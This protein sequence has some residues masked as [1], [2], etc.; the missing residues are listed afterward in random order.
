[1]AR[2]PSESMDATLPT[3]TVRHNLREDI[4]SGRL[5][6]GLRLKFA[7]LQARYEASVGTL[8]EALSELVADGL[9]VAETNRGFAVA[10]VSVAELLDITELR[11]DLE[12]KALTASIQHGDDEWEARVLAAFHLLQ[13]A[14]GELRRDRAESSIWVERH[15]RFHD[16]LVSACPSPWVLRFRQTLFD[17]ARRYRALSMKHSASPGRMEE[18]RKLMEAALGRD[19]EAAGAASEAHI[20]GTARN[21]LDSV[22]GYRGHA[23]AADDRNAARARPRRT[24]QS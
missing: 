21:I 2:T 17:Q 16:A 14:E 1:M 20:R 19:V 22:P 13:R 10:P 23:G 7:E 4:L 9:V 24:R 6:P 18:H 15:R 3:T 11:V 5:A 12:G 8:R